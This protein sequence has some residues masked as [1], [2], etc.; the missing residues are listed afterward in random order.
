MPLFH[1][2][3]GGRGT[4]MLSLVYFF[5]F[6]PGWITQRQFGVLRRRP[7][8][9]QPSTCFDMK[10]PTGFGRLPRLMEE[11]SPSMVKWIMNT[12]APQVLVFALPRQIWW[13]PEFVESSPIF[14]GTCTT[15]LP[16]PGANE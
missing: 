12:S 1:T 10:I 4:R 9:K 15:P 3:Q 6:R 8:D 11:R 2:R 5:R 7:G 13:S 14:Q 16:S